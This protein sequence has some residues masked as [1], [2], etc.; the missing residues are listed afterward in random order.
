M[1]RCLTGADIGRG[2]VFTVT[3]V[4]HDLIERRAFDIVRLDAPK[5]VSHF[6]AAQNRAGIGKYVNSKV[7]L[8]VNTRLG[9]PL[10]YNCASKLW[11]RF[12]RA[13]PM[14]P[15]STNLKNRGG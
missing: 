5:S 9:W 4:F 15:I 13:F 10:T 8:T 7:S 3:S 1:L 11:H 2:E 14:A 12:G 6:V